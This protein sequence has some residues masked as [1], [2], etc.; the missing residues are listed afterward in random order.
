MTSPA[1]RL[2]C[3]WLLAAALVP[4]AAPAQGPSPQVDRD[5]PAGI[6]YQLPVERAR[7]QAAGA[8]PGARR[9]TDE[10]PLFG[11]GVKQARG[12]KAGAGDRTSDTNRAAQ[13]ASRL[14]SPAPPVVRAEAPPPAGGGELLLAAGATGAG[15]LLLGALAGLAWR[16]RAGVGRALNR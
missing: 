4:S 13:G 14:E 15:V 9:S 5:S 7:E 11:V 1:G 6:E 16:R 3:A 2:A 12:T 10:I 8:L